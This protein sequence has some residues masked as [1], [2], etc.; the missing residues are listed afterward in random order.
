MANANQ[1]GRH[2]SAAKPSTP[3]DSLKSID[4]RKGFVAAATT[5]LALGTVWAGSA[6]AAPEDAQN[7]VARRRGSQGPFGR[8]G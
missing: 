3:F 7:T 6:L 4:T 5:G 2:R 8:G 1:R